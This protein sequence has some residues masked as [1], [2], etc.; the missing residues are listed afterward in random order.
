MKRKY[1]YTYFSKHN[2]RE[3]TFETFNGNITHVAAT[4]RDRKTTMLEYLIEGRGTTLFKKEGK[5]NFIYP[6]IKKEIASV[7]ASIQYLVDETRGEIDCAF[8]ELDEFIEKLPE[9]LDEKTAEEIYDRIHECL[10]CNSIV[11][12][13]EELENEFEEEL[14]S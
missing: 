6:I 7:K 13:P 5:N 12:L 8:D 1:C 2:G 4:R 11:D 14:E 9:N 3:T 10:F